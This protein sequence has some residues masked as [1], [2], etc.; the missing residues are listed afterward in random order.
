MVLACAVPSSM[1]SFDTRKIPWACRTEI[2]QIIGAENA[3]TTH[4]STEVRGQRS[5]CETATM[6]YNR[7]KMAFCFENPRNLCAI[8]SGDD[9]FEHSLFRRD[10]V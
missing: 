8:L 7:C 9:C 1:L 4:D 6:E 2:S 10:D 5:M 3:Q